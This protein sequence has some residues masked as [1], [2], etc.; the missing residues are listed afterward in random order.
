[1]V[2]SRSLSAP[3]DRTCHRCAGGVLI[4]YGSLSGHPP[5][6]LAA[7]ECIGR[8]CDLLEGGF[9]VGGGGC[10]G[11]VGVTG[12]GAGN[13]AAE[14]RSTQGSWWLRQ[15]TDELSRRA[16]VCEM[17]WT[18][19]TLRVMLTHTTETLARGSHR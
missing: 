13:V 14:W 10:A 15:C 5:A 2:F 9:D 7:E 12:I 16:G 11:G 1:M 19:A 18:G 6:R 3:I 4:R 8:E 17:I